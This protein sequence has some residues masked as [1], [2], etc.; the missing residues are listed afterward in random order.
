MR[1]FIFEDRE[2][3]IDPRFR[4]PVKRE[5]YRAGLSV[6]RRITGGGSGRHGGGGRAGGRSRTKEL[7]QNCVAKMH[8]SKSLEAHKAQLFYLRREGTGKD[9]GSAELYGTPLHEYHK[10]MSAKNFR[11]FLSPQSRDV[12]LRTLTESFVKRL[13]LQTGH[14][15]YWQAAEHYNTAHP[16]A[17]ILINGVDRDGNDVTIA[18]DIVKT[19]MRETARDLCTAMIGSRTPAELKADME[20]QAYADRWTKL[21]EKLKDVIIGNKIYLEYVDKN[22]KKNLFIN[23]IEHLQGL[24]LCAWNNDHYEVK[25]NWEEELRIQGRYN[26]YL[27]SRRELEYTNK[28]NLKLYEGGKYGTVTGIVTKIYKTDDVSDNHAVLLE[29]ID[30]KAYFVPLFNKPENINEK[31][32]VSIK[33]WKNQKGRLRPIVNTRTMESLA[34]EIKREGHNNPLADALIEIMNGERSKGAGYD[35]K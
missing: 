19:Y 14:K 35:D 34:L 2:Y 7:R 16:H 12:K 21:D 30:G 1:H 32:A 23:R 11:I 5:K 9:G 28:L 24:G 27:D 26:C 22:S 17:H 10:N 29:G 31:D 15:F 3:E 20:K 18:P 33:A 4:S 8:Y 13:E 6:L 25:E